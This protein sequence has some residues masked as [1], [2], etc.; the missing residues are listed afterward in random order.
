M[1]VGRDGKQRSG[2]KYHRSHA[3][4]KGRSGRFAARIKDNLEKQAK[5]LEAELCQRTILKRELE[6]RK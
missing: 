5:R 4:G 2:G 1:T 3:S 6:G